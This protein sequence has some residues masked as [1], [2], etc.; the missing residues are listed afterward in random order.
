MKVC[1]DIETAPNWPQI[2]SNLEAAEAFC[3]RK[4]CKLEDLG[5][6]PQWG[7]VVAI[8]WGSKPE[9]VECVADADEAVVL[10]IAGGGD[11]EFPAMLESDVTLVGHFIKGFDIPFLAFRYLAHGRS[12]PQALRIAGRKPWEIPHLDTLELLKFGGHGSISLGDACIA[13]GIPTPKSELCG[14]HV[15]ALAKA[16]EY[17]RIRSYCA[18]DVR[19]TMAL[20]NLLYR[21]EAT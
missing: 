13:L 4:N 16:G 9:L 6:Y 15:D 14:A 18:G 10:G 5:L 21:L 11:A 12:L 20:F 8:G 1:F 2:E 17:G 3:T 19:A 7:K